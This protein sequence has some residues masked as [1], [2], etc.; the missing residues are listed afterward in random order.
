MDRNLPP[1]LRSQRTSLP[2]R[3]IEIGE[4]L[5][6]EFLAGI[7][8]PGISIQGTRLD[9]GT[10]EVVVPMQ[11]VTPTHHPCCP[12]KPAERPLADPGTYNA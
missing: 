4:I 3:T 1:A 9:G 6:C 8:V 5:E 10:Y 2:H 11:R 12:G 7:Q